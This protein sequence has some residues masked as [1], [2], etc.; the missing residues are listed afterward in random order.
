MAVAPQYCNTLGKVANCQQGVFAAYASSK[1]Y[2][3][4]D[5]HLYIPRDWFDE[6]HRPLRERCGVP[7]ALKFQ[8]EP[9]LALEMLQGLV[10]G[11]KVPFGWVLAD[12]HF[13]SNPA[14]LDGVA[15]LGK[16]YLVE[17][18]LATKVG[19][20]EPQVEPPGPGVRGRPRRHLRLREGE[21]AAEEV[22]QIAARL[23]HSGW[24]RYTRGEGSQGP[25]VA[26]FAFLRVTRAR[27]RRPTARL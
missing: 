22:R 12:E 3:F 17:V 25:L 2:T 4:L 8:T 23:P 27:R 10:A 5:R 16:W 6:A 19:G 21:P 18:P 15:A 20:R 11:G 9:A 14:F 26:E 13:G 7:E 1:G 24:R